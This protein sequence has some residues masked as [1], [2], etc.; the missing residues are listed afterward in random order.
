MAS[1]VEGKARIVQ[2][3]GQLIASLDDQHLQRT[4]FINHF[5]E[6]LHI[7]P[8][9]LANAAA[10]RRGPPKEKKAKPGGHNSL[11]IKHRQLLEF[12]LSYP[13]YWPAFRAGRHRRGSQ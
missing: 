2:D 8:E 5:S 11:P 12:L 1:S 13:Q 6:K 7:E 3:L 9:K 10:S 4:I